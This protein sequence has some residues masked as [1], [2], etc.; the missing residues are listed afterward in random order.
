ME[1]PP[2]PTGEG[3]ANVRAIQ[4]DP[5]AFLTKLAREDGDIAYFE[6]G[7]APVFFLNHPDYVKEVLQSRDW[8]FVKGLGSMRIKRVVGD[9]LLTSEGYFHRRQRLLTQPAF[10]AQRITKYADAMV[11]FARRTREGWR[12]GQ[13]VDIAQEM[14]RVTLAIVAKVLFDADVESQASGIGAA[15]TVMMQGFRASGGP[16]G[17]ILGGMAPKQTEQFERA[18]AQLVE[19]V[20]RIIQERRASR[21]DRGDLLSTLLLAQDAEG[22]GMSDELVRDEVMT[23]FLAGH[24]TTANALTW[25]WYLLSQN[26]EAEA[27]L[28]AEIDSVLVSRLPGVDDIARLPYTKMVFSEVMRLYPPA[29]ILRRQALSDFKVG[30]YVLPG[31]S[32]VVVS[33]YVLHR[34]SRFYPEPSKFAPERWT[35]QAVA[36]RHKFAYF[37]FGSGTRLCIGEPFAWTEGLLLI[38]TFA[39][40]WKLRLVQGHAVQLEPS[41]TLRPTN[42]MP[43]TVHRR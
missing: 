4:K 7:D 34:D 15:L 37:P 14:T 2:G 13:E 20:E 33:Q 41:V 36:T 8:N 1:F 10:H 29:W 24:E 17:E 30:D 25:T 23:F 16:F 35:P 42:G 5:I 27:K 28:H 22:G 3:A 11:E 18:R 32:Y 43:M 26:T 31:G 40:Q 38:A 12:E 39:Q 21:E 19:T 6:L 9:G